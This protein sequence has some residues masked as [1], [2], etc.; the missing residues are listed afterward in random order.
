MRNAP[1]RGFVG[2]AHREQVIPISQHLGHPRARRIA[3]AIVISLAH[4]V[5]VAAAQGSRPAQLRQLID[6][7]VGGIPEVD[8]ARERFPHSGLADKTPD[9]CFPTIEAK[10]FLGKALFFDPVRTARIQ[11]KFGG[12]LGTRLTAIMW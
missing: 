9:P 5:G 7:Q 10:R 11:P 6:Q 3:A 4:S 12:V 8:G 2:A 1:Q